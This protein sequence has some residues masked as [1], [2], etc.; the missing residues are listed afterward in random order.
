MCAV[1]AAMIAKHRWGTPIDEEH[2]LAIAAIDKTD[3]ATASDVFGELR[4]GS[5][6]ATRGKRGIE[7]DNS[8]FGSIADV[9]YHECGWEPFQAIEPYLNA[10]TPDV[11]DDAFD[12]IDL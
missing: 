4:S 8:E 5:Y 3:Y 6:I 7:L 10:P 12:T 1:L 2:L 9:L 11:V